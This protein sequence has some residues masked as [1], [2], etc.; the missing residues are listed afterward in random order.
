MRSLLFSMGMDVLREDARIIPHLW[1]EPDEQKEESDAE[2]HAGDGGH[3]HFQ[4]GYDH[5]P[6]EEK[7]NEK[8][9]GR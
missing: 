7:K 1:E 2:L 6:L 3:C 4:H 5:V 8:I 9:S